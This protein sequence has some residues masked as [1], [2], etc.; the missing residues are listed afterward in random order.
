MNKNLAGNVEEFFIISE[1]KK[2]VRFLMN[3][4]L[5]DNVEKLVLVRKIQVRFF[6]HRNLAGNIEEFFNISETVSGLY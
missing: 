1:E 5:A 4:N 3:S 6:I 2:Q